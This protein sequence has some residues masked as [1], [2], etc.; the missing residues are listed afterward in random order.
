M[1]LKKLGLS[2]AVVIMLLTSGA[3]TVVAAE[4]PVSLTETKAVIT[5]YWNNINE[6]SPSI[7]SSEH[8]LYSEVYV[9]AKSKSA[10]IS[11][12]MYLENYGSRQ[13]IKVASWK[14]SGVGSMLAS[15]SYTG[16]TGEEYR[17]RVV[18]TVV[19]EKVDAV[20]KSCTI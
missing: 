5:P 10:K 9:K 14:I 20:S 6:V 12:T 18:V 11:G 16:K 2:I 17:T 3:F 8:T 15:K 4:V 19:S 7:S 1:K 13:W